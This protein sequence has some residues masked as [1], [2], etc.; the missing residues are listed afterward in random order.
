MKMGRIIKSVVS[1]VLLLSLVGCSAFSGEPIA[2]PNT[3][4]MTDNSDD[5]DNIITTEYDESSL[6]FFSANFGYPILTD[7][8]SQ[9]AIEQFEGEFPA[10]CLR[11]MSDDSFYAVYKTT[12]G[13]LFYLFYRLYDGY[14]LLAN[15][16]YSKEKLSYSDV[17]DIKVGDD[18]SKLEN[19]VSF[20]KS[21]LSYGAAEK[22][23]NTAPIAYPIQLGVLLTDGVIFF[24]IE[25]TENKI[26]NI[27]Y[28]KDF[29]IELDV[30]NSS[31]D[32]DYSFSYKILDKDRI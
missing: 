6:F 24:E 2:I 5:I 18:T 11:K 23:S 30:E 17:K 13:G 4:K 1:V 25:R 27:I 28:E 20:A 26:T 31:E 22:N 21:F 10:E 29:V 19:T 16:I 8:Y 15:C 32:A 7:C 9:R 3:E 12:Q 14:A